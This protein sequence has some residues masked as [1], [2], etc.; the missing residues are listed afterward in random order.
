MK[1][2]SLLV[3][4]LLLLLLSACGGT[5]NNAPLVTDREGREMQAPDK[6]ERIISGS[7]AITEI[8]AELGLLDK[9]VAVDMYGTDVAGLSDDIETIDML[10][11]NAELLISLEADL[12]LASAMTR[13]GTEDDPFAVV[14][15]TGV[16]VAYIP[17]A[18]SIEDICSDI[19]FI[20]ELTGRKEKGEEIV[21]GMEAE[22]AAIKE[23]AQ[24]I[25]EP[26]TVYFEVSPAPDLYSLGSG[27]YIHELME[28][29]GAKNIF[30][31]QKGWLKVSEESVILANPHV[32]L[33]CTNFLDDA[34]GEIMSRPA[35]SQ[36]TAVQNGD[37]YYIDNNAS[38]RPSH[39]VIIALKEMAKAVYPEIYE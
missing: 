8:L 32:I 7:A 30:G 15:N 10:N 18:E 13:Q 35:W 14:A 12:L 4:V 28:I 31:E 25:T 33:T 22:I 39:R 37:V 1:K 11:P 21:A 16:T 6:V 38:Q 23:K 19:R 17:T 2:A 9:V 3:T 34:I 26:K 5:E 29:L 36:I 20:A 27:T 24:Q